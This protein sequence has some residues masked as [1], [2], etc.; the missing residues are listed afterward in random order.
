[1][2]LYYATIVVRLDEENDEKANEAAHAI[3]QK[4]CDESFEECAWVDTIEEQEDGA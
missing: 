4:L 2:P 3:A 1:M